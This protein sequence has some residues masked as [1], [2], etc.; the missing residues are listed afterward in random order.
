MITIGI[1]EAKAVLGQLAQ[2]AADGE[3]VLLTRRGKPLAELRPP[4]GESASAHTR[5][6]I[7]ALRTFRQAHVMEPFDIEEL[8]SEG[9]R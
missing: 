5:E 4:A 9:R 6:A 2:A 8:V 3:V 7:E 1:F